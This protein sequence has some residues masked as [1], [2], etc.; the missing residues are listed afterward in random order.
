MTAFQLNPQPPPL[1]QNILYKGIYAIHW[2]AIEFRGWGGL[3]YLRGGDYCLYSGQWTQPSICDVRIQVGG[4]EL[5]D[6]IS[7]GQV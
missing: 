1:I 3:L 7:E 5:E 4:S 2:A 6:E